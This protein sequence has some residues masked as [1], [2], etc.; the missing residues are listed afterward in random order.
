MVEEEK[1]KTTKFRLILKKP[2]TLSE[3]FF[4]IYSLILT[5]QLENE[6]YIKNGKG[7]GVGR[8]FSSSSKHT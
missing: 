8:F 5:N 4:V 1:G 6:L 2:L 3:L 7:W